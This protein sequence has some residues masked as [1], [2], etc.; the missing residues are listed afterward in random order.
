MSMVLRAK[1]KENRRRSKWTVKVYHI[2]RPECYS[3]LEE[4]IA[5]LFLRWRKALRNR[6]AGGDCKTL[7]GAVVKSHGAERIRKGSRETISYVP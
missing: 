7:I 4:T 3:F 6:H 1:L 5:M 2:V